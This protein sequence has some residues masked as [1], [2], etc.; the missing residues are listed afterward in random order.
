VAA[1]NN[2]EQDNTMGRD[3][4]GAEPACAVTAM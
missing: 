4:A 1:G 2:E 3:H